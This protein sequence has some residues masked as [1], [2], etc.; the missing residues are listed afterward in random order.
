MNN[1]NAE[2]RNHLE[3]ANEE[4]KLAV[5]GTEV[6]EMGYK[7]PRES[8]RVIEIKI[9]RYPE[10]KKLYEEEIADLIHRTQD[11]DGMPH[12]ASIS[13]PTEELAIKLAENPRLC[14]MK[15]EIDAVESV[16]KGLSLEHQRVIKV[17]Y[18]T[19]RYKNV[20][21]LKMESIVS[22]R[23]AQIRRICGF[24]IKTVGEK[25]GEI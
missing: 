9:R 22:Y 3:E 2:G 19:N 6:I 16:Y 4:K 15:R 14:R 21:Y 7:V 8:W 11:N 1:K 18:W 5:K 13:N 25:L 10:S 24:F 20:S 23:E 12:G 17:R